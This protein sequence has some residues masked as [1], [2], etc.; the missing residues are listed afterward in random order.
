[1]AYT[2]LKR[3]DSIRYLGWSEFVLK[4]G[5]NRPSVI[6]KG[7]FMGI[8]ISILVLLVIGV[9]TWIDWKNPDREDISLGSFDAETTRLNNERRSKQITKLEEKIRKLNAE[10]P[11][12]L[13]YRVG[14][15]IKEHTPDEAATIKNIR[16][17]YERLNSSYA[18]HQRHYFIIDGKLVRIDKDGVDL[19]K[20]EEKMRKINGESSIHCS[21]DRRNMKLINMS[22]KE[23]IPFN[24]EE[25]TLTGD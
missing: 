9:I 24:P 12:R 14:S 25:Y 13:F 21:L 10:N 16:A 3:H 22:T 20:F 6:F 4:I 8:V 5:C 15:G 18:S 1:M 17:E 7:G 11:G 2:L 19:Y 23:E